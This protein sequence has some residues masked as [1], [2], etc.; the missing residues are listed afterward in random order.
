MRIL[1]LLLCLVSQLQGAEKNKIPLVFHW[2][3]LGD[4][5]LSQEEVQSIR[6]W[7][8]LHPAWR[9]KLWTN[10]SCSLRDVLRCPIDSRW[11]DVESLKKWVLQQEGGVAVHLDLIA[12]KTMDP[13]I[14][15]AA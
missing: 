11:K 3:H 10:S 2:F 7:K 5:P 1:L 14:H 8:K 9:F 12:C 13:L 4:A 15:L 6:S